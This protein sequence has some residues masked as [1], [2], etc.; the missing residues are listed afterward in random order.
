ME[1][2]FEYLEAS[3][4]DVLHLSDMTEDQMRQTVIFSFGR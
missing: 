4:I 1:K 3:G 2:V